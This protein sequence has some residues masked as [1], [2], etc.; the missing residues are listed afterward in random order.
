MSM[1]V[2]VVVAFVRARGRCLGAVGSQSFQ[3]NE[4]VC[5]VLRWTAPLSVDST[6]ALHHDLNAGGQE[7]SLVPT[8]S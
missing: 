2:V 8:P 1:A 7:R 6:P 4:C 3:G 5:V